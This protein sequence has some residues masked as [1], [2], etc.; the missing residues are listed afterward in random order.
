MKTPLIAIAGIVLAYSLVLS[1]CASESGEAAL[2]VPAQPA[3][4]AAAQGP[5]LAGVKL[6]QPFQIMDYQNKTEGETIP[7]WVDRYLAE[8]VRGVEKIAEFRNKY[9]FVGIGEGS[10]FRALS[11]WEA[12]FTPAQDFAR[13]AAS[14]IEARLI[15]A[16][17][18]AIPDDTY[19][20]FFEALIK[21]A[22][23]AQYQGAVKETGFWLRQISPESTEVNR[24]VY[25]FLV[26]ISIDKNQ[27]ESQINTIFN[28]ARTDI[29]PRRDQAAA[30][31][32]IRENFF[33]GF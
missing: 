30:I 20:P 23:D 27:L 19:G 5:A 2:K 9:I 11:Q 32:R 8:G 21:K 18:P 28:A 14:R 16:A 25:D 22:S 10:N 1:C 24:E 15:T 4:Y 3:A 29:D 33:E 6:L 13:L 12:A 7:E 26:L 17:Q 31:N